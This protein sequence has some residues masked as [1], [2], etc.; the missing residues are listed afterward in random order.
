M[1]NEYFRAD[2]RALSQLGV[3]PAGGWS[4]LAWSDAENSAHDWFSDRCRDAGLSVRQDAFGNTIA[5][6]EGTE[7]DLPAVALGSHLDTVLNGGLY[8]GALG[9]LV[10]L[11]VARRVGAGRR[12]L[13]IIAF[14][15]EEGWFGPF[16][17]SR[18]M[19]G[20][21][22][23]TV[24]ETRAADGTVLRE[25]MADAG[26]TP[27]T[28]YAAQRDPAE[29]ACWL[30]LHIEQGPVLEAANLP[31][32]LVTAIAGQSR[33]Y[34]RFTG[35][36]G[37]AGTTPMA[38]RRD[39]FTAAA[40]FAVAFDEMIRAAPEGPRGTI[41]I[42]RVMPNQGNV[43]PREVRINL[44]I[45]DVD[46]AVVAELVQKTEALAAHIAAGTGTEAEI[47]KGFTAAPVPMAAPLIETLAAA[48][49]AEGHPAMRLVSGANHDAGVLGVL[50]PAAMLFVPSKGGLS[51]VPEEH[52]DEAPILAAISVLTRA[53]AALLEDPRS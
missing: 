1:K 25:I 47:R 21:L 45:R 31:L 35:Q 3:D 52:T 36:A 42:V 32:G 4:R 13:E 53:V 9:V 14:R 30:E 39:A 6:R 16:T 48:A 11:E 27:D 44:E 33:L 8:D 2:C 22:P 12:P 19:F 24:L 15:D 26:F 38:G 10:A 50:V 49:E 37:H 29:L 40:R 51:H 23:D 5:R 43:I 34:L 46:A 7:P 18:A 17:G 41:G 20:L 28:P